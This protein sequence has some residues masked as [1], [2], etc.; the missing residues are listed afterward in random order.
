MSRRPGSTAPDHAATPGT[1]R[2]GAPST[3]VP[4]PATTP[5]PPPST[6][7]PETAAPAT[8]STT[9]EVTPGDL[10]ELAERLDGWLVRPA[11]PAY[12]AARLVYDLRYAAG[13]PA[14]VAYC[15]SAAD[16]AACVRFAA[17]SGTAPIP[18]CGGHSYGGY[19]TGSG[20]V[21]DVTP[22]HSVSFDAA[23]HAVVG[24]G[25]LLVDLYAACAA[26]GVLVPGGSC[27]TVGIAG[28]TL[29]GGAGVLARA[30]GLT[31][32]NL[33]S[34]EIVTAAGEL[35]TCSEDA[36]PELF[37]A[38]RGGGGRN[39]GIVTS[40]TF[41]THPIPPLCLFTLQWPFQQA[42]EVLSGWQAFMGEAPVELWSNCQLLY[43][44]S[45]GPHLRCSGVYAGELG[46]L[47]R[48]L[49]ALVTRT[50]PPAA[51]DAGSESYL[52]TMLAEGGCAGM[53]VSECHLAGPRF[54]GRPAPARGGAVTAGSSGAT[55]APASQAA[56]EG[57]TL[58]RAMFDATSAF[59]SAPLPPRG[60]DAAT[61]AI[62]AL[63]G[64]GAEVG[65][66][67]V[68]DAYGGVINEVAAG[69]TAFVHRDALCCVQISMAFSPSAAPASIPARAA[70]LRST[71]AALSPFGNGEAYQN[72]IDPALPGWARAYYGANLARLA[73]LKRRVDPG[74]LFDFPQAVPSSA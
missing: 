44:G 42:G 36:D 49:D 65:A 59:F 62:E 39:F 55:G 25:A 74:G 41:A 48:L 60:V 27:P 10:A 73:A 57:G 58:S 56:G 4:V 16:V 51:R 33:V 35:V 9:S 6:V 28:L 37:W 11:D 72:Y 40:F 31:C 64:A 22:M 69:A 2:V 38:L 26:Q 46:D 12:D 13:R 54:P 52:D 21:V 68:F 5:P 14:A 29:G 23:G 34:A 18:R 3:S 17:A 50:G 47:D 61:A 1:S 45:A 32:D 53:S 71:S 20:L 70:W 8:S 66:G 7:P 19:S 43:E 67:L 15:A 63:A 30:Y 24:A